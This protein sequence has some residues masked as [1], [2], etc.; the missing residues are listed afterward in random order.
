MAQFNSVTLTRL[1]IALITKANAGQC[2]IEFTK[3]QAGDGTWAA[4]SLQNASALKAKKQ[5]FGISSVKKVNDSTVS[6]L[7]VL[8]NQNLTTGY[9]VKEYGIFAR[10]KDNASTEVLYAIITAEDGKEDYMPPFNSISPQIIEMETYVSVAN[11]DSVTI[12]LSTG[13]IASADDLNKLISDVGTLS[14]LKTTVKKNVIGAIN[15]LH[16]QVVA[17]KTATDTAVSNLEK[18]EDAAIEALSDTH[19]TD[20][21]RIDKQ[22]NGF[23]FFVNKRRRLCITQNIDVQDD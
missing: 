17:N 7:G 4:G 9:Y 18:K 15:E 21:N 3:V 20:V 5:E 1:G 8:S 22:I 16:D 6:L 11:A 23:R 19:D 12:T 13:A 10:E 2:Q 14:D